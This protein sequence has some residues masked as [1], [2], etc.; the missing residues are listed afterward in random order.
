MK[1]EINCLSK[2]LYVLT[3]IYRIICYVGLGILVFTMLLVPVMF[4][5]IKLDTKDNTLKIADTTFTYSFDEDNLSITKDNEEIFNSKVSATSLAIKEELSKHSIK[6]YF[7]IF[8][9]LIVAAIVLIT[10]SSL[11]ALQVEK[12]FKNI[13]DLKTPF[14]D[15]NIKLLKN[16][17]I[18]LIISALSSFVLMFMFKLFIGVNIN[19]VINLDIILYILAI[20]LLAYIFEY[21]KSLETKKIK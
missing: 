7:F 13:C 19:V 15:A 17:C 9:Y 2:I 21:G 6:Y 16:I 14:N 3:K 20:Y 11:L 4:K 18:Y 12:L 1:K 8:E 5:L 10:I